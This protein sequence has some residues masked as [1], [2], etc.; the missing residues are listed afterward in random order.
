MQRLQMQSGQVHR[1]YQSLRLDA[2]LQKRRGRIA[3]QTVQHPPPVAQRRQLN[4]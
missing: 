3:L 2:R 1:R 4:L